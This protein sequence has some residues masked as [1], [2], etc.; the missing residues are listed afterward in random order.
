MAL[1]QASKWTGIWI[2][3]LA[4]STSSVGLAQVTGP[5]S[6]GYRLTMLGKDAFGI[7]VLQAGDV[8]SIKT[9]GILGVLPTQHSVCPMPYRDGVLQKPSGFC[10]AV[11][12]S[13]SA[14]FQPG[15]KVYFTKLDVNLKKGRI[16]ISVTA[17]DACNKTEPASYYRSEVDFEFEKGYL[18]TAK[19]G[20][21]KA[22]IAQV[23]ALDVGG[24]A[25]STATGGL[26]PNSPSP[27]PPVAT[28]VP[29]IHLNLPSTY[30]SVQTPA[31]QLQLNADNTFS[32]QEAG[33]SYTGTFAATGNTVRLNISGGPESTATVQGNNL[34]DSS[35]QTWVLREQPAPAASGAAVLQNQ[36]I[37]KMVKAG[38]DDA[39]IMAKIAG[40]KCQFDTST[41]ALIQL[42]QS[43]V[44]GA[45]LKAVV[46]AGK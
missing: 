7:S 29:V 36:D 17:C 33:Q 30:V 6:L 8:F 46:G 3:A 5:A 27:A 37:I 32:L 34:T 4:G 31:D 26:A 20:A 44:S 40:S 1:R 14:Y 38:L 23:F 41:D 35:G 13:F 43:G 11:E 45:V 9:P 15:L 25:Q 21:V 10:V 19:P 42:K 12:R 28:P 22:T 18:E 39:I 16:D 24:E 2:L